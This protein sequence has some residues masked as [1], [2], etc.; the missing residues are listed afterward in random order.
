MG[1][2]S[3]GAAF[4]SICCMMGVNGK[5]GAAVVEGAQHSGLRRILPTS[6]PK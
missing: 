4:C 1:L 5:G 3:L 6:A 2:K